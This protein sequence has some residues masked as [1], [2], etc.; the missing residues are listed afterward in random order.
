M[1]AGTDLLV[2]PLNTAACKWGFLLL[3]IVKTYLR[4]RLSEELLDHLMVVSLHAKLI[5]SEED[6]ARLISAASKLWYSKRRSGT[7]L[8]MCYVICICVCAATH[9]ILRIIILL[10][11][12]GEP[13]WLAHSAT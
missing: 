9:S 2:L 10:C 4:N 11:V 5:K 12:G 6:E 13:L 3:D 8:E 1:E 7:F